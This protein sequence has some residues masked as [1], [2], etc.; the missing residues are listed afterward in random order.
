MKSLGRIYRATPGNARFN[1]GSLRDHLKDICIFIGNFIAD[2]GAERRAIWEHVLDDLAREERGIANDIYEHQMSSNSRQVLRSS[3]SVFGSSITCSNSRQHFCPCE[4][5]NRALLAQILSQ[6]GSRHGLSLRTSSECFVCRPPR[7]VFISRSSTESL[8]NVTPVEPVAKW[9]HTFAKDRILSIVY[10][11]GQELEFS[12]E[13]TC[14]LFDQLR[15]REV[16]SADESVDEKIG[17]IRE[18]GFSPM[19]TAAASRHRPIVD[20]NVNSHRAVN[21][22]MDLYLRI[23]RGLEDNN[24]DLKPA[25]THLETIYAHIRERMEPYLPQNQTQNIWEEIE[26]DLEIDYPTTDSDSDTAHRDPIRAV[27]GQGVESPAVRH[28]DA[29]GRG[30]A[31]SSPSRPP[32]LLFCTNLGLTSV[33]TLGHPRLGTQQ[34]SNLPRRQA[35]HVP[36]PRNPLEDSARV[37]RSSNRG[38][39]GTDRSSRGRMRRS[40]GG[41]GDRRVDGQRRA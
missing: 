13:L 24:D 9:E 4:C 21:P 19:V 10:C 38:R 5:P 33:R 31:G 37:H 11:I 22:L 1:G 7:V 27:G 23:P 14:H 6:E 40:E 41:N 17:E 12:T 34:T 8:T 36:V 16:P 29:R 25:S 20:I 28:D 3:S 26:G 18:H 15:G 32:D 30:H 39:R 2:A 35:N